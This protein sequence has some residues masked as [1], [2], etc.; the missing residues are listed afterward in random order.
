MLSHL[1]GGTHSHRRT[2]VSITWSRQMSPFT[3]KAYGSSVVRVHLPPCFRPCGRRLPAPWSPR[4]LVK[5]R[6]THLL[7]LLLDGQTGIPCIMCSCVCSHDSDY[8]PSPSRFKQSIAVVKH[9]TKHVRVTCPILPSM[10]SSSKS[11][12]NV[13]PLSDMKTAGPCFLF[14]CHRPVY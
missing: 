2:F 5:L 6:S 12:S 11:P 8:P 9:T 13:R 14:L 4:H 10:A 7:P 1:S 3:L